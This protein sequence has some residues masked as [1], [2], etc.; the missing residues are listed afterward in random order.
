MLD[1]TLDLPPD[2]YNDMVLTIAIA[3]NLAKGASETV[4]LVA[5]TPRP[6]SSS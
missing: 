2:V 5:F 6:G 1:G 3:T 4:H